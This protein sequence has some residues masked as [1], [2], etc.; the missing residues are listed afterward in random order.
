[1]RIPSSVNKS[2]IVFRQ[3]AKVNE[4]ESGRAERLWRW[5]RGLYTL[6]NI[7]SLCFVLITTAQSSS[8]HKIASIS[9]KIIFISSKGMARPRQN[10]QIMYYLARCSI[11]SPCWHNTV[12]LAII[13]SS[14]NCRKVFLR[15]AEIYCGWKSVSLE[16]RWHTIL[17]A[18]NFPFFE[19]ISTFCWWKSFWYRITRGILGWMR[20]EQMNLKKV[21]KCLQAQSEFSTTTP[22][23]REC[24]S[25]ENINLNGFA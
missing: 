21:E 9:S 18:V 6:T 24:K 19:W 13:N 1:M 25:N 11:K 17:G 7:D 15:K 16:S 22:S 2:P 4:G 14:S 3:L 10:G 5:V 23:Q 8:Q 12:A 20:N